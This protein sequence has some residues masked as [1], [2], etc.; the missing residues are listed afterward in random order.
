MKIIYLWGYP[1]KFSLSYIF[2][3]NAIAKCGISSIYLPF[4]GTLEEFKTKINEKQCIGANVTA[5]FKEQAISLVDKLTNTAKQCGAINT[6]YKKNGKIIGDN[7]DGKGLLLWLK[8]QK[9]EIKNIEIIGNG[10]SAKGLAYSF[11][12]EKSNITI[13]GR[14]EKGWEI[15]FGKFRNIVTLKENNSLKINTTPLKI[16]YRNTIEITYSLDQMPK[17]AIGMLSMQ[18]FLSF[19][20]WFHCKNID[21]KTFGY[22]TQ[23]AILSVKNFRSVNF[24]SNHLINK[25]IE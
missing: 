13:F 11:F 21:E 19:Q 24:F 4:R 3:Q 5:P 20:K 8:S 16:K 25:E 18:G 22:L 15:K 2:Q 1:L 6:I 7:T 10:G 12:K 17:S 23:Q 14:K 9:K